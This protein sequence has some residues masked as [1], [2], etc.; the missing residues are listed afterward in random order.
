MRLDT[1][2][3]SMA[4]AVSLYHSLGF[5]D[6]EPYRTNPIPGALYLELELRKPVTHER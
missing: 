3:S 5:Y 4:T 1:I 6:I 2:A